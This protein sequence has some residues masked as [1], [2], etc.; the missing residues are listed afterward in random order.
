MH[1]SRLGI[2]REYREYHTY[3]IW[4]NLLELPKLLA[5]CMENL[6]SWLSGMGY[7]SSVE[8]SRLWCVYIIVRRYLWYEKT[9]EEGTRQ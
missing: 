8:L 9:Q 7:M 6:E 4:N 5:V 1:F 3:L 2:R